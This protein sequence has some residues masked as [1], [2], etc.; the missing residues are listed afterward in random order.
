MEKGR[1]PLDNNAVSPPLWDFSTFCLNAPNTVA[2][3]QQQ[4]VGGSVQYQ[5]HL[6]G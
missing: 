4:P 1:N 6:V 5:P 2:N 3:L